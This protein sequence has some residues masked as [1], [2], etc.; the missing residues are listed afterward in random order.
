[1]K[2]VRGVQQTHAAHGSLKL[3]AKRVSRVT[4]SETAASRSKG[5]AR[6]QPQ[7]IPSIRISPP[8]RP[9]RVKRKSAIIEVQETTVKKA[10]AFAPPSTSADTSLPGHQNVVKRLPP[11]HSAIPVRAGRARSVES[12]SG[13]RFAPSD[14]AGPTMPTIPTRGRSGALVGPAPLSVAASPGAA[15]LAPGVTSPRRRSPSPRSDR[16]SPSS[17][18]VS[19]E[20]TT[21]RRVPGA[22][23]AKLARGAAPIE[24]AHMSRRRRELIEA[25]LRDLAV[26]LPLMHAE[27]KM[28]LRMWEAVSEQLGEPEVEVVESAGLR[29]PAHLL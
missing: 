20:K 26:A 3:H 9:L 27:A 15:S 28:W 4:G 18:S 21:G 14:G 25:K 12:F 11:K 24:P 16:L 5:K 8:H 7:S 22:G 1:M 13:A 10:K 19:A 17:P 2:S 6:E 29:W 23:G